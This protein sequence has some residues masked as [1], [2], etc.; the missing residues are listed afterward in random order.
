[1]LT[2]KDFESKNEVRWCPGCGDHAILTTLQKTLASMNV[3]KNNTVIISG[4]GCSSRLP[5]YVDVNGFHTIH[6]RALPV[7]M[8]AL[9]ANPKLSVWIV[10]GDGDSLS[11]GLSHLMHFLRRNIN[12]KI[13]LVNNR[14]YGL[15]KGQFSPTSKV[16]QY[17]RTSTSGV[18][19]N[20][21]S[22]CDVALTAGA[23]FVARAIDT[24]AKHLKAVIERA[25]EHK[26]SAFIEVLQN[27][28]VYNDNIFAEIKDKKMQSE[29]VIRVEQGQPLVFGEDNSK[30]LRFNP[31]TFSVEVC[32]ATD[33]QSLNLT[34]GDFLAKSISKLD[35]PE[36][37]VAL[38]VL[39]AEQKRIFN[40]PDSLPS[41]SNLLKEA[42]ARQVSWEV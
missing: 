3:D 27:C 1:M 22:P 33:A 24:E 15:T 5:F 37:P 6:G 26:G 20:E 34:K 42:L 31:E 19:D 23:T 13:L 12:A 35:Y 32:S 18:E 16:G 4:I 25:Q 40:D 29:R 14:I 17:S 41:K 28:N 21:L 10:T 7:A 8:G 39:K 2:K 11:I 36:F 30:G 9:L 38:G